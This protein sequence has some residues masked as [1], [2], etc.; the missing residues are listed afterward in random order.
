MVPDGRKLLQIFLDVGV[1]GAEEIDEGAG[2][3]D[4][5]AAHSKSVL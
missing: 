3:G 5:A 1:F 4:A 2:E